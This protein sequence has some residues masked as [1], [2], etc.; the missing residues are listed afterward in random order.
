M[1]EMPLEGKL[2]SLREGYYSMRL[3]IS[4]RGDWRGQESPLNRFKDPT[5]E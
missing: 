5:R 2:R 3:D 1:G 4:Q